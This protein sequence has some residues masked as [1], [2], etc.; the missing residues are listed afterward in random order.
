M[1]GEDFKNELLRL[2]KEVHELRS[3]AISARFE[4]E[5]QAIERSIRSLLLELALDQ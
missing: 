3:Y 5:L 4:D 1:S 2:A